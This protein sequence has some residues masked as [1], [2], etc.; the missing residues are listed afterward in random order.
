MVVAA[1]QPRNG[2][3]GGREVERLRER[4]RE[5]RGRDKERERGL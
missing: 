4:E 1:N 5:K 2:M 3:V